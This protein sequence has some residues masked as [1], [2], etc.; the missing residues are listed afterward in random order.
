[1]IYWLWLSLLPNVG[2]ILQ[3]RL[4][5]QFGSPEAAFYGGKTSWMGVDGIGIKTAE[6]IDKEKILDQAKRILEKC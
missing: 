6:G 5:N 3:K 1:M 4:L 2:P